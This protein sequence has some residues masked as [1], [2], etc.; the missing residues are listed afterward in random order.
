[1]HTTC[2]MIYGRTGQY[3]DALRVVAFNT[4]EGWSRDVSED[5]AAEV[6]EEALVLDA[7]PPL[8]GGCWW[9]LGVGRLFGG[10]PPPKSH[11]RAS[12]A[13]ATGPLVRCPGA[14]HGRAYR[15]RGRASRS[16]GRLDWNFQI[17]LW[18]SHQRR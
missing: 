17:S 14:H 16:H 5:I 15:G 2:T 11:G 3:S 13:M 6:L 8:Y 10:A 18:C 1:L 9:D 12:V 7:P 4:A